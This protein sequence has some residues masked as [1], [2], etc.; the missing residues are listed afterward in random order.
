MVFTDSLRP[1]AT[2]WALRGQQGETLLIAL[3]LPLLLYLDHCLH[4]LSAYLLTH[5]PGHLLCG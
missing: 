3:S 1:P 2:S 5:I 4:A